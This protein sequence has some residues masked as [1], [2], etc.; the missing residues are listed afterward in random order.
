V[1]TQQSRQVEQRCRLLL[2]L[3]APGCTAAAA[4]RLLCHGK[5]LLQGC[6]CAACCC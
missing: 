1:A 4:L 6:A 2:L 5:R 3:L